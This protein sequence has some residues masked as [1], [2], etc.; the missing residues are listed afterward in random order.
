MPI[1][2]QELQAQFLKRNANERENAKRRGE[3]REVLN[4]D[5][6]ATEDIKQHHLDWLKDK[7]FMMALVK[8]QF[9]NVDKLINEGLIEDRAFMRDVFIVDTL[10]AVNTWPEL[11]QDREFMLE[12][13]RRDGRAVK[14]F[15]E[16]LVGASDKHGLA[17]Y[18]KGESKLLADFIK[19]HNLINEFV[20]VATIDI[21]QRKLI[22]AFAKI[23]DAEGVAWDKNLPE[24]IEEAMK[25]K[26]EETV[27]LIV[28]ERESQIKNAVSKIEDTSV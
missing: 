17:E 25:K 23:C 24:E 18:E 15:P 28:D 22:D 26:I 8:R 16:K 10:F 27:S 20:Y 2:K 21:T 9:F 5:L 11:A 13:A 12:V 19:E 3:S 4:I 6:R 14:Y 1:E 7:D